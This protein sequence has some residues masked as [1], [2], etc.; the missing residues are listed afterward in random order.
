M[1]VNHALEHIPLV[2]PVLGEVRR[3][4][5][6][7]GLVFISVPNLAAWPHRLR[8][9]RF[10]LAFNEDHYLFFTPATLGRLLTDAGFTIVELTTPRW[11]DFQRG[12]ASAYGAPFRV[13][14]GLVERLGLG[15]EIFAL[16]RGA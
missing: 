12:P 15:L 10:G 3:V 1:T 9:D 6:P 13:V 5:R 7:G 8:V 2:R 14:N 4:L 16:A 11:I